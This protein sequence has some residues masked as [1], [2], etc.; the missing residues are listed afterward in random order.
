MSDKELIWVDKEIS[1]KYNAAESD[2]EQAKIMLSVI[3]GKGLDFEEEFN[4]LSESELRFKAICLTHKNKLTEIY[5]EQSDMLYKLWEDMG[6]VGTEISNHA[7][8]VAAEINPIKDS[9]NSLK[10]EIEQLKKSVSSID[11]YGASDL[12]RIANTVSTMSESSKEI[13]KF[14]LDNYHKKW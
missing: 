11:F 8:K 4:L 9:V 14:L 6:D 7:E 3:K 13:L 5:K 1:E 10:T 2:E 12:E